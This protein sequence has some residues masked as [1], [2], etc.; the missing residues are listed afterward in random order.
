[1]PHILAEAQRPSSS[2]PEGASANGFVG[3]VVDLLTDDIL[4]VWDLDRQRAFHAYGF[5]GKDWPIGAI[6]SCTLSPDNRVVEAV[7]AVDRATEEAYKHKRLI[8]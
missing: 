7:V 3:Q 2:Q 1:M 6:V 4:V 5:R 8:P